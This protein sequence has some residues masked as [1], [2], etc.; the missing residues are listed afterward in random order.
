MSKCTLAHASPQKSVDGEGYIIDCLAA[1]IAWLGWFR[2]IIWSD[3]T[4]AVAKSVVEM[5]KELKVGGIEQAFAEGSV[6]YDMQSSGHAESAVKMQ[7]G[8]LR[9][10]HRGLEQQIGT[11]VPATHPLI[12]WIV[13]HAAYT[14]TA[15]M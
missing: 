15:R 3:N 9:A 13:R 12:A 5:L 6:P 2:V 10:F 7:K 4:P 1:D 8:T 14:R 11:R